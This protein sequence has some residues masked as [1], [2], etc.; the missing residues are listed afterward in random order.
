MTAFQIGDKIRSY[1]FKPMPD[2]GDC[3]MDG[4]VTQVSSGLITFTCT[5]QVFDGLDVS[6]DSDVIGTDVQTATKSILD[7]D[8]RLAVI[9]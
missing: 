8:G 5:R 2:H 9:K 6:G 7:W 3:Y 1:D 4:V